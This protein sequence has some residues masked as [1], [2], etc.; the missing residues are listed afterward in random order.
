[1]KKIIVCLGY[2]IYG[3][4]L[5]GQNDIEIKGDLDSFPIKSIS[6]WLLIRNDLGIGVNS[7]FMNNKDSFDSIF[8]KNFSQKDL[9]NIWYIPNITGKSR[10]SKAIII[11]VKKW[12]FVSICDTPNTEGYQW[13]ITNIA[14]SSVQIGRFNS[15]S[16]IINT[17]ELNSGIYMIR[18]IKDNAIIKVEKFTIIK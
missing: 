1:M 11:P 18:V 5:I 7:I 10:P 8:D 9:Y 3:Q 14:G 13:Q 15:H 6:Q 2:L 17:T 16:E 4:W 12:L